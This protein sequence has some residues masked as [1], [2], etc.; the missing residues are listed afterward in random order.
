MMETF[1]L[2][3][4]IDLSYMEEKIEKSLAEKRN[5]TAEVKAAV[6]K[7]ASFP[8]LKRRKDSVSKVKETVCSR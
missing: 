7:T 1:D 5:E 2:S 4:E 8:A 6:G 3:Q